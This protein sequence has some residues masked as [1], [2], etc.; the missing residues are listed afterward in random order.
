MGPCSKTTSNISAIVHD[1]TN[2]SGPCA[3]VWSHSWKT[4]H[5][6]PLAVL[7]IHWWYLPKCLT[8][9]LHHWIYSSHELMYKAD[10]F[11][12]FESSSFL[13]QAWRITCVVCSL[14]ILFPLALQ[15]QKVEGTLGWTR[16]LW[17]S[18]AI[19]HHICHLGLIGKITR[20]WVTNAARKDQQSHLPPPS[21]ALLVH[22]SF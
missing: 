15:S 1:K 4:S 20:R 17:R 12:P 22:S 6:L 5:A 11:W 18:L 13:A 14:S 16:V 9:Q 19:W 21:Q 7:Q 8:I 3:A 2:K 10:Q